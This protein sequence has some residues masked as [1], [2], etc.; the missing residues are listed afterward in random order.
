MDQPPVGSVGIV[1]LGLIGGS[2][3]LALRAAW[4]EVTLLGCDRDPRTCRQALDRGLVAGAGPDLDAVGAAGVVVLAV[5]APAERDLLRRLGAGRLVTDVASTKAAVTRWAAEAG[6]DFVGGHPM[7]G[8]EASGLDAA[9]ADLFSGAPWVLTRAHP[10]VEALVRAA[11]A[12]PVVIDPD[13][14]DRLVAGVSQA[15]FLLS[16]AY[17][18][19]LA[20]D[21]DWPEM[22]RLAAG[23]YRD[24][25]R[26]AAGDPEMYAGIAVTNREHI[27][28]AL[29]SVEAALAR[30]R[31]HIENSDGRLVELFEE[32]R[33]VRTRWEAEHGR[34]G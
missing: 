23:G 21:R 8:V 29:G 17:V 19:A 31:R 34:P 5:P 20:G 22:A 4:P 32:A 26:L 30:L 1:G 18:L 15:A 7:A 12:T 11:G 28:A 14:H 24:M 16:T 3:A 9:R 10:V 6:V 2:L 27:L 33:R 25:S 13:H